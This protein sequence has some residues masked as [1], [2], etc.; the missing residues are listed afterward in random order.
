MHVSSNSGHERSVASSVA[1]LSQV[2]CEVS[3]GRR[4]GGLLFLENAAFDDL[5][6]APGWLTGGLMLYL[7]YAR[8]RGEMTD[9]NAKE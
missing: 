1:S 4:H 2:H 3:I 6:C 9:G 5:R 8:R 7:I